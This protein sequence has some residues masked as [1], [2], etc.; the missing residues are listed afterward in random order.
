MTESELLMYHREVLAYIVQLAF[1][2]FTVTF[3]L[4]SLAYMVGDRLRQEAVLFVI[5]TYIAI[6]YGIFTIISGNA[7]YTRAVGEALSELQASGSQISIVSQILIQSFNT[8]LSMWSMI[9]QIAAVPLI[10]IGGI[11]YLVYRHREGR[12]TVD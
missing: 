1:A 3:G 5:L 6:T 8:E 10:A 4:Y 11:G 2:W 9:G 12:R 7:A